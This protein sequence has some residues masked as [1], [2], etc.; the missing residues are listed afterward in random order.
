MIVYYNLILYKINRNS[1]T[2]IYKVGNLLTILKM[3]NI[4]LV[5]YLL[6]GF[7]L[8]TSTAQSTSDS[9]LIKKDF[10]TLEDALKNPLMVYRL[11]LG[12]S[13]VQMT[14]TLWAKFSNLEYL[15]LGNNN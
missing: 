10:F 2:P 13:S 1:R 4:L 7:G 14:D 15:S 12:N 6:F 11:T 9:T 3:K 8:A 5:T